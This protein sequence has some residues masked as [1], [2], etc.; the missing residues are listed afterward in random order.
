MA[1]LGVPL[2]EAVIARIAAQRRGRVLDIGT[3]SGHLA[4]RLAALGFEAHACD[5]LPEPTAG[6]E[7]NVAY[8]QC[9]LNVGLPYPDASFDY[10]ACLEVIEHLD[11]PFA[12]CREL[13]RVLRKD[14]R[15]YLSTPNILS[16]RSRVRFLLDGSFLYF[17]WPPIEWHR[18][19]SR[20]SVHVHP[21]RYHELEYYLLQAGLHVKAAFTNM[22]SESWKWASPL[23]WGIRT[24]ARH[25]TVR[26]RAKHGI[27]LD[28][29]YRRILTE[30]LLYGTH[31]IVQAEPA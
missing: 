14:G 6:L 19:K 9:D 25:R 18:H 22:R 12:L 20:P 10:L 2:Q 21:I 5:C 15:L 16:L 23:V 28:R 11:D 7:R 30:D 1:K 17:D 3:E 31:L 26:A 13:R 4:L 27:C 29:I 24:Y 8:R